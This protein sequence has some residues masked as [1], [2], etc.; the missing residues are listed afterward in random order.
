MPQADAQDGGLHLVEAAVDSR[1]R[2]VVA[3]R[4][5]AVACAAQT[6]GEGGIVHE[7]GAG[8]AER[9]Q[10]LG[11]VEAERSDPRQRPHHAP[12]VSCAVGLTGVLDEGEAVVT[13]D[14]QERI[15]VG[16]VAVEVHGQEGLRPWRDRARD[17][18][19]RDVEGGGVDVGENRASAGGEDGEAGERGGEGRGHDLVAGADADRGEGELDRLRPA[20]D[21]HRVLGAAGRGQLALEGL[22]LAAEDEPA[23]VE[24][25]P[26]GRLQLATDGRDAGLEIH[27]GDDAHR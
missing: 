23:R 7:D 14:L 13:G 8:V 4:L 20:R 2:V 19:G 5:P 26:H 22:A 1:L 11:G 3:V 12:F 24:D 21:P 10:V 18:L 16:R 15:E 27:E 9:A 25:A 17:G 6:D